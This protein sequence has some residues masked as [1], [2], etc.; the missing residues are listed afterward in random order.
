ML[1]TDELLLNYKRC[2]RRTYLEVYGNP[3]QKDP[4]KEFLLK[5]KRENYQ[6]I[7]SVLQAREQIC[8]RPEVSRQNWQLNTQ[9]TL[10]LMKRG[11]ECIDRGM[12]AVST[13]QWQS[14]LNLCPPSESDTL[15][16]IDPNFS[17]NFLAAPTLLIKQP[18]TSKFGDW[19]YS[20]IEIKLGRRPKPEYKMIVAFH[21][22]ILA[23]IQGVIPTE[24]E[25]ILRQHDSY[26]VNLGYWLPKM[27]QIVA[28]CIDM[29]ATRSQ[30]EVFISRQRCNL[31]HWYSHC[32]DRAKSAKHLSLV[33]GITPKRHEQLQEIGIDTLESL[34]TVTDFDLAAMMGTDVASQLKQQAHSLLANIPLIK[35][36]CNLANISNI[37]T[38]AIEL[39]FDIEAE[40]ERQIDYLLG[41]LVVDR[42]QN[43]QNFY[44]FLAK[45][46]D[47]EGKIWQ[48]FLELISVYPNAPIFHYS[49]YEIDTVKRLA[50]LYQTPKILTKLLLNR[51][52]DL[53]QSI[54]DLVVLPVESYSLK[55]LANWIGFYWRE[56]KASGDL[57]VCWYDSWLTQQDSTFLDAILSYNEDD[58]R[59]TYY[60]K[61]WLVTFLTSELE[62]PLDRRST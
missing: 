8:Q 3:A 32:Y 15:L 27:Q 42:Q 60:L 35:T 61:D 14:S 44:P 30:P 58:C 39:Y 2:P 5:L 38:E 20:S 51:F 40:P 16:E 26:C 24:S 54:S 48:Q 29:L 56:E 57:C 53:H 62:M 1:I 25:L 9:Q 55:A 10:E 7:R 36:N 49:E 21:A 46:P 52:I 23:A 47:E 45:H 34:I 4:E 37:P 59:A 31:C 18:G 33:P 13:Q 12:L 50:N 11:V 41:V 19:Y 28:E 22:Q 43:T 6:H 17:L